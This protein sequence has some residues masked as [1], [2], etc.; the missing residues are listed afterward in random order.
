MII[1]VKGHEGIGYVQAFVIFKLFQIVFCV[2]SPYV[3]IVV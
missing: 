3:V 1:A 2:L